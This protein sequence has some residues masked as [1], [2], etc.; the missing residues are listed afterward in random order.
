MS[1]GESLCLARRVWTV[2]R[3]WRPGARHNLAAFPRLFVTGFRAEQ[4]LLRYASMVSHLRKPS[5]IV[6]RFQKHRLPAQKFLRRRFPVTGHTGGAQAAKAHRRL[7]RRSYGLPP[8][9]PFHRVLRQDTPNSQSCP[10]HPR[11]FP[12]LQVNSRASQSPVP[13]HKVSRTEY[14]G[15]RNI[16]NQLSST[17]FASPICGPPKQKSRQQDSQPTK[18]PVRSP[19]KRFPADEAKKRGSNGENCPRAPSCGRPS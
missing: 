10:S 13:V 19:S 9:Q 14:A 2:G 18:Q 12:N 6:S 15:C 11:G 16:Q 1:V 5:K 7:H 4:G 17:P 8:S 3:R